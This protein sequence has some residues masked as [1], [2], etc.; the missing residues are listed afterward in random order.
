MAAAGHPGPFTIPRTFR[1]VAD[2]VASGAW[3]ESRSPAAPRPSLRCPPPDR[4]SAGGPAAPAPRS[5]TTAASWSR[6]ASATARRRRL[7]DRR[8]LGRWRAAHDGRDAGQVALRRGVDGAAGIVRTDEGRWR[9]YVCSRDQPPSKHWW[10]DVL[11]AT[12]R[13]ASQPPSSH[14]LS[15]RPADGGQGSARPARRRRLAGMDLLPPARRARRG[16][17]HDDGVRD[18]RRRP[19]VAVARHGPGAAP[20][21]LGPARR[22]TDR[23]PRRRPRRVRRPRV[24][25][26]ELV[27]AHRPRAPERRRPASSSRWA[28]TRV[29]D[30]RYLEVLPSRA[31]ATASGTRHGFRTRATSCEPS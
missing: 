11:E 9:L 15:R 1:A 17:P 7:D 14:R 20:G 13:P 21:D 28:T 27:R 23:G 2:R 31:A 29:A 24:E 4:A 5:T 12:T 26:G 30:V 3:W 6:T 16:G 18:E 10:I 19:R 8:A 25:G 22:P